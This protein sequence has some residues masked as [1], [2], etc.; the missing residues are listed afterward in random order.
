ME[1]PEDKEMK[2]HESPN[3]VIRSGL[4]VEHKFFARQHINLT[5][6]SLA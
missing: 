5:E 6:L 3:L 2:R 1:N 4:E